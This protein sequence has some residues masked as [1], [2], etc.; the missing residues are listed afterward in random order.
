MNENDLSEWI[1]PEEP[2]GKKARK[3]LSAEDY[4]TYEAWTDDKKSQQAHDQIAQVAMHELFLKD[5]VI[6]Q[7]PVMDRLPAYPTDW[8]FIHKENR[9]IGKDT[10]TFKVALRIVDG[11][12][13]F[14][15]WNERD[16]DEFW[17]ILD[18][19]AIA[20]EFETLFHKDKYEDNLNPGERPNFDIIAGDGFCLR[21]DA[22]PETVLYDYATLVANRDVNI[23]Q[24]PIDDLRLLPHF[25]TLKKDDAPT[26]ATV[27]FILQTQGTKVEKLKTST[28]DAVYLYDQ[29]RRFDEVLDAYIDDNPDV[30]TLSLDQLTEKSETGDGLGERV[31]AIFDD[32]KRAITN[33]YAKIGLFG[34][35]RSDELAETYKGIWFTDENQYVV[36]SP[37]AMP[38]VQDKAQIVREVILEKGIVDLDQ[39]LELTSVTFVRLNQYTV[40]PYQF[41]LIQLYIDNV[42]Q[43]S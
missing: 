8:M 31:R 22:L 36:G 2:D 21:I 11:V 26:R 38:T 5:W 35:L 12:P 16:K 1:E 6:Y 25:D 37:K 28:R 23:Q 34:S 15:D 33:F 24:H 41:H 18:G 7:R 30:Q 32:S 14:L 42:L 4:L 43:Y 10:T 19:W 29:L 3:A 17:K 39:L 20:D 40:I 9:G 27:E 13:Q